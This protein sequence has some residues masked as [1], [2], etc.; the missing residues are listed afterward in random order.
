M[1]STINAFFDTTTEE[2]SLTSPAKN[3]KKSKKSIFER[4]EEV[5]EVAKEVATEVAPKVDENVEERIESVEERFKREFI[6]SDDGVAL[7]NAKRDLEKSISDMESDLNELRKNLRAVDS[8]IETQSTPTTEA[9]ELDIE[10]RARALISSGNMEA[11]IALLKASSSVAV[12]PKKKSVRRSGGANKSRAIKNP[13]QYQEWKV[14]WNPKLYDYQRLIHDYRNNHN[15]IYYQSK[16]K[17]RMKNEPRIEDTVYVSC[18]KLKIMKCV[19]LTNFST[20]DETII[21]NYLK[22]DNN[23]QRP[24][25]DKKIYLQLKIVEIYDDP[26][27]FLGN[28]RTWTLI[29]N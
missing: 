25:T 28:Q 16:G 8:E 19:V 7:Y 14:T 11:G 17:S 12:A 22:Y 6:E 13:S 21:D 4:P 1:S 26:E 3:T 5:P 9:L 15:D 20:F 27:E 24:H 29:K 23:E 10:N 2:L 18:G